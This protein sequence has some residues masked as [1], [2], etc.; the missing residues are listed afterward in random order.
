MFTVNM[1]NL[2]ASTDI[3]LKVWRRNGYTVCVELPWI[4]LFSTLYFIFG[5]PTKSET[6]KSAKEGNACT[7]K[8]H[9]FK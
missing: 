9:V 6:W 4:L 1:W 7:T 2:L 8:K 3:R 5:K